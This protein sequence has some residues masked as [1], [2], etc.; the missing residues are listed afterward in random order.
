MSERTH[1][2]VSELRKRYWQ[3]CGKPPEGEGPHPD[4]GGPAYIPWLEALV[5]QLE[6]DNK[7]IRKSNHTL[8]LRCQILEAENER[9]MEIKKASDSLAENV[10]KSPLYGKVKE[11]YHLMKDALEAYDALKESER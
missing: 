4:R 1:F 10:N 3:E 5:A 8:Y 9:L 2:E 7:D 11:T 6:A